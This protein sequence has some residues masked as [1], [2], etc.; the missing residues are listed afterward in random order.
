MY[1]VIF[2]FHI[3]GISLIS[4]MPLDCSH[5]LGIFTEV[6]FIK[7]AE[8]RLNLIGRLT[9]EYLAAVFDNSVRGNWCLKSI[10]TLFDN[11]GIEYL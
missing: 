1:I 3:I 2:L 6:L 7:H 5:D 10:H 9:H 11:D 8:T 4:I